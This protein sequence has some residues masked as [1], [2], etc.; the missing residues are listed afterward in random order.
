MPANPCWKKP[1]EQGVELSSLSEVL[2]VRRA[3]LI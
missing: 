1:V 3:A 2:I